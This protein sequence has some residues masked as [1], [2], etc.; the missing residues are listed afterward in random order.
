LRKQILFILSIGISS[1]N[2]TEYSNKVGIIDPNN[3]SEMALL[4][5]KMTNKLE[6]IKDRLDKNKI[7]NKNELD[8]AL[9]HEQEFTDSSFNQPH[10]RRMSESYAYS[11]DVF[12][13]NPVKKNYSSIINSCMNCHQLSCPGPIVKI[14][15]LKLN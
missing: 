6:S 7:I 15:K 3:S 13:D 2:S 14:Q 8:F 12:N 1:C 4:M 10:I 5:R 11:I 9:I